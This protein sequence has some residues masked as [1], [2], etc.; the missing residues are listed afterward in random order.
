MDNSDI[1]EETLGFYENT[2]S[3]LD[4]DSIN[5]Q[6]EAFIQGYNTAELFNEDEE[7]TEEDEENV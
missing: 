3:L 6:E 5:N 7:D 2:E 1:E 4:D